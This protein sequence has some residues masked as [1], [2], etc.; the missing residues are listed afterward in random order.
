MKHNIPSFLSKPVLVGSRTVPCAISRDSDY[1]Y[2][3]LK[4][5][6][7][8]NV[9]NRLQALGYENESKFAVQDTWSYPT[10]QFTSY[11][12]NSEHNVD[13]NLIVAHSHSFYTNF[14]KAARVCSALN[15]KSRDTRV[16]VHQLIIY[17]NNTF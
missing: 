12:Y 4:P 7:I 11:R 8:F 13:V 3:C 9:S 1:D 2:L 6:Y 5:W 10:N 17:N 16:K 14:L 15:I